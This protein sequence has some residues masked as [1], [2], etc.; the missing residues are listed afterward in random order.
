MIEIDRVGCFLLNW[1]ESNVSQKD[2]VYGTNT[3][4]EKNKLPSF[5]ISTHF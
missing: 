4:V 3:V 1:V 5:K 2:S